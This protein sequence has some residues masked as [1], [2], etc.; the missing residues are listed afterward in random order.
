MN[1]TSWFEEAIPAAPGRSKLRSIACQAEWWRVLSLG[2]TG[3]RGGVLR[4]GA[5]LDCLSSATN[6]IDLEIVL[7]KPTMRGREL[8][9]SGKLSF[10][11]LTLCYSDYVLMRA[12]ARD[13]IGRKV[14]T[15]KWDN[16]EKAYWL[17]ESA[18]EDVSDVGTNWR[19]MNTAENRVTYSSNAR[20][21]RYGKGGK[22]ERKLKTYDVQR[23]SEADQSAQ[24][25]IEEVSNSLNLQFELDG[26]SLKLRRDDLVEGTGESGELAMAFH[27]D[28]MLLRVQLVEISVN[29]TG[30][31]DMSFHLS[32][33]RIGLFDLGDRGRL[34]RERYYSCLPSTDFP[35]SKRKALRQ[36]CPF[37][38]LAEGYSPTEEKEGYTDSTTGTSDDPQF[39]ITVDRCPASS[40][41]GL[42]GMVD[43]ELPADSKVTMARIVI[44]YLSC[45]ALIRPFKEMLAFLSCEWPSKSGIPLPINTAMPEKAEAEPAKSGSEVKTPS[46]EPVGKGFQLKLVAHYPRIFFL[47]D[48]SDPNSRALVLR[49]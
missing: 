30:S 13:N 24:Q 19:E 17:E 32:L 33:F 38:V 2:I 16:V 27:Y 11:D 3:F 21:I 7:R 43:C 46:R 29:S 39:V 26:L 6:P 47:A 20:F 15:E 42:G 31:G 28:M 22:R 5:D 37:H 9:L 41:G 12:V 34:L 18:F 44:N 14:D 48:E 35:K 23:S 36:P 40:A 8:S 49:G 10:V 25:I 4:D 45:N 1:V